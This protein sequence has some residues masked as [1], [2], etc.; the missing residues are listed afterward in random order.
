MRR[1]GRGAK[2]LGAAGGGRGWRLVEPGLGAAALEHAEEFAR[3]HDVH[4]LHLMVR[5]ENLAAVR[6]C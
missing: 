2:V 3:R 1:A 5:Q 6:L 4:A